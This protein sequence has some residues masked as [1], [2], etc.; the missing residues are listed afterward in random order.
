MKF[1]VPAANDSEQAESVYSS[2]AKFIGAPINDKRIWKL[3]WRHNGIINTCEIGNEIQ[4]DA[5]FKGEPVLAIFD[6]DY[7]LM[8]CTPNRGGVRGDPI[9]AGKDMYTQITYFDND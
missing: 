1:F 5:R 7:V 3:S 8:I 6:C 9:L 4:G 2:F